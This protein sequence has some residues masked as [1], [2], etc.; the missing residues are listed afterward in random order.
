VAPVR[1]AARERLAR[2]AALGPEAADPQLRKAAE[3]LGLDAHETEAVLGHDGDVLA[4]G[5]ALAKL[6]GG[7]S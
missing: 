2:R 7:R 1:D 6:S 4:A 3:Q 5:R